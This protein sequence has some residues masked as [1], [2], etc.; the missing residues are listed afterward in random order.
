[1]QAYTTTFYVLEANSLPKC[2]SLYQCEIATELND[3]QLLL[4]INSYYI[5]TYTMVID[6]YE[7][8]L[9]TQMEQ[10]HS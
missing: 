3:L 1:M 2:F 8:T 6:G 4:Q 9:N 5:I 10:A 7:M